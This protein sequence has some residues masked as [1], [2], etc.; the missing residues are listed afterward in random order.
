M[1][2]VT[3]TAF[4]THCWRSSWTKSCC[5]LIAFF[6]LWG[7]S[8]ALLAQ[9]GAEIASFQVERQEDEV[10][11]TAQVQFEL[12]ATVEDALLKGIPIYFV[13]EAD[14][15]RERWYWYDKR[16]VTTQRHMRLAYQ[17]LTR[18]WRLNVSA[19][20]GRESNLGLALNQTYETLAQALTAIKRINAWRL[21]DASELELGQ[22]YR[23]EFR[24]RLDLTQ[25]PRPFQ[26]GAIGQSDWDLA[27]VASTMWQLPAVR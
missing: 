17:P 5:W 21:A 1:W 16:L 15:L 7:T 27:V 8:G 4:T 22:K 2:A 9:S 26:I 25:L 11:L 20:S 10:F 6:C 12:T 14:V 19:A 13:A 3:T 24:F 23:V 18:R